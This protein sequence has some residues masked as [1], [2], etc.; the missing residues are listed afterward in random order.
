MAAFLKSLLYII[1][2]A[3]I[4]SCASQKKGVE[5]SGVSDEVMS[6]SFPYTEDFTPVNTSATLAEKAYR[7]SRQRLNYFLKIALGSEYG[8]GDFTIKKW[9]ADIKIEIHGQPTE[10]DLK[11]LSNVLSDLRELVAQ[12]I[13]IEI[14]DIDGNI[15][16]YFIPQDEFYRYEP[17]GIVFYGGFF[18]NWWNYSGEIY[19][20]RIVI[21]A[22]RITQTHRSHLIREELTQALGLMNDAMDYEDSIFFQGYSEIGE[23]SALD[24]GI[25][26]MLYDD[27]ISPG[28]SSF[29]VKDILSQLQSNAY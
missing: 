21:A 8:L 23:Y 16:M 12:K 10:A 4:A 1:V 11:T 20:S 24:R 27:R 6:H 19:K 13:N 17:P 3:A 2:S 28:M 5:A 9:D 29:D 22:D 15:Q 26:K 18:W 14:V 7:D 25:I